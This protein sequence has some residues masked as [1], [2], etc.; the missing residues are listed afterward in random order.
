VKK[1]TS[2][3]LVGLLLLPSTGYAR[4]LFHATS[5]KAAERIMKRGFSVRTMNPNARFGKGIYLSDTKKLALAEKP[6]ARALIRAD[7]RPKTMNISHWSPNKLKT[8][9]HDRDLR[10]N[11]HHG[12]PGGDLSRKIGREAGKKDMAIRYPSAKGQ[13]T[14]TFIPKKLYETRP[15]AVTP[16][17][18]TSLGN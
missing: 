14:N 15:R 3:L 12:I 5:E 17:R 9:S 4:S 8:F 2:L 16:R 18:M 6:N 1:I 10:G 13:G 7:A 11:I